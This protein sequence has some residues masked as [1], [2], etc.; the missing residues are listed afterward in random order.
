MLSGMVV[1]LLWDL[2]ILRDKL[3][4]EFAKLFKLTV[5]HANTGLRFLEKS[6]L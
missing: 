6:K 4:S 1:L 2:H 3:G 5:F